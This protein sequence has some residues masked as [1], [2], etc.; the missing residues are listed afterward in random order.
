MIASRSDFYF[1]T[2]A[3]TGLSVGAGALLAAAAAA[4][5]SAF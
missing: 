3:A 5:F 2:G 4:A 1:L